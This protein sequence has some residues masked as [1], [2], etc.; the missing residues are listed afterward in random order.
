MSAMYLHNK[1]TSWY[2]CIINNAINRQLDSY[3]ETH[4]IIP[5]SL[6]GDNNKLN[7]VELTAREHF[8][9][10]WLLTKMTEGNFKIKM[11]HAL[12][13]MRISSKNQERYSTKITS[14]VYEKI[15]IDL[16]TWQSVKNSGKG[17][18]MYGRSAVIENNL[19]WYTNGVNNVYVTKDTQPAGYEQG[20]FLLSNYTRKRPARPCVSPT[21]EIFESLQEAAEKYNITVHTL[22]ERIRR[23]E[24][25]SNHRKNKSYWSYYSDEN[26]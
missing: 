24:A 18:P 23:N 7:L 13:N 15:K 2:Y 10:H 21:G 9:C 16:S 26:S 6:N 11:T 3:T 5:K 25:N 17:N 14:R 19:T 22:R 8:I 12:W 4:H 1:Y 20:R